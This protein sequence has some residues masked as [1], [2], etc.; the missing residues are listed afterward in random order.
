MSLLGLI[1]VRLKICHKKN[2]GVFRAL[3]EEEAEHL[4]PNPNDFHSLQGLRSVATQQ[5]SG[6]SGVKP[7]AGFCPALRT[8]WKLSGSSSRLV[9]ASAGSRAG[10]L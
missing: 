4:R 3:Q 6:C 1:A 7:P 2:V 8:E 9:P 5:S 10:G